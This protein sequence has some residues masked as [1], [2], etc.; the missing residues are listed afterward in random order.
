MGRWRLEENI[1]V[2]HTAGLV[3]FQP[4]DRDEVS[5]TNAQATSHLVDA[6]IKKR[7][8]KLVFV[9]SIAALGRAEA[10][11][12][13]ITEQDYRNSAKG[14]SAYSSSKYEAE[15]QVWRGMAEGL[16]AVIVN[17]SIILGEGD[18]SKGSSE[19]ISTVYRGLKFFTRGVNGYVDVKDVGKAMVLLMKSDI[20]GERFLVSAENWSYEKLFKTI[21]Q[22]LQVKGPRLYAS[23]ILGSFAW[24][25]LWFVSLFSRKTPIITK[26]T[27]RNAKSHYRYNSEK[28]RHAV[29]MEFKAM[30][31]TIQRVCAQ[32]LKEKSA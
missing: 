23:P 16:N 18:W 21:A 2:Y 31:E 5:R 1:E 10:G 14:T 22:N 30:D 20:Q 7:V 27:A 8:K 32:F 26:D 19:L 15:L 28:I 11:K 24:R 29:G 3:S 12:E 4:E 13:A 17:P 9:S 25:L 6:C